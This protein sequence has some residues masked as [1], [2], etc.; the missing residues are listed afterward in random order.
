MGSLVYL[1]CLSCVCSVTAGSDHGIS[2]IKLTSLVGI[3]DYD[4][5]FVYSRVT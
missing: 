4:D 3:Y 2:L 1:N 5:I